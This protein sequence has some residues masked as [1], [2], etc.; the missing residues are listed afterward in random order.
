[1]HKYCYFLLNSLYLCADSDAEQTH[2]LPDIRQ[3]D[4]QE[5]K[6][7]EPNGRTL[8]VDKHVCV[9]CLLRDA[10][11]QFIRRSAQSE[12][13]LMEFWMKDRAPMIR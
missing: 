2:F 5:N 11:L 6:P 7:F 9:Y 3:D 1:M 4:S 8:F 12:Q 13:R 10:W